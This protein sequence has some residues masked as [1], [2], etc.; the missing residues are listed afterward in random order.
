MAA[1]TV[2]HY[3]VSEVAE[4]LGVSPDIVRRYCREGRVPV[5]HFQFPGKKPIVYLI[6]ESSVSWFRRTITPRSRAT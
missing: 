3:S 6:P 5:D 4:M 2:K 1:P